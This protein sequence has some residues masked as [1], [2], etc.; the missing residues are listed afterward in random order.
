MSAL[1]SDLVL[2]GR[3][4]R[5]QLART[6]FVGKSAYVRL[7]GDVAGRHAA[8]DQETRQ[9][10]RNRQDRDHEDREPDGCC[11]VR[12]R[13]GARLLVP[14]IQCRPQRGWRLVAGGVSI[15]SVK[16][17]RGLVVLATS[18]QAYLRD[19]GIFWLFLAE[20]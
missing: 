16:V 8:A 3:L 19:L 15:G 10:H 18:W 4:V 20:N 11:P 7:G 2:T 14:C 13:H 12:D 17:G 1:P 6:R 9:E 5:R